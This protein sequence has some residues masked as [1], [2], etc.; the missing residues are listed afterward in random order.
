MVFIMVERSFNGLSGSGQSPTS[1]VESTSKIVSSTPRRER[2]RLSDSELLCK[3]AVPRPFTPRYA[4]R[5]R[6]PFANRELVRDA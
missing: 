6:L 3:G 2:D 5:W 4:Q 1:A